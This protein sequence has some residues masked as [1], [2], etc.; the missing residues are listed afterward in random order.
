MADLQEHP[1]SLDSAR[2]AAERGDLA[3]WVAEFLASPGSDNAALA[4]ILAERPDNWAGPVSL[5]LDQLNRL[6]GPPGA[7]VLETVAE[8][9]WRD[10]VE[11]LKE[12]VEE[13]WEPPPLVVTC[14]DGDFLVEDGNHRIEGLR[15]AGVEEAWSIVNFEDPADRD[16]FVAAG[17]T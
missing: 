9:E 13:G 14:K 15:R 3:G 8:E 17:R 1:Y 4:E 2:E 12:R 16:R 10:D 6:A 5:P 11:D 7:P